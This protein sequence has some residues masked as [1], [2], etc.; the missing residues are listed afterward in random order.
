M[1]SYYNWNVKKGG[2]FLEKLIDAQ[3]KSGVSEIINRAKAEGRKAL[4]FEE[5][6]EIMKM[7]GI[8][9]TDFWEYKKDLDLEK[10]KYPAAVKID[11]DKILHKTDKKGLILDIKDKEELKFAVKEMQN[12]FNGEKIIIQP[13][14]KRQTELILGIKKDAIFGPI[15]MYGLGGI[16]TEMLKTVDFAVPP[17]N[18]EEI[19][20]SLMESKIKFLFSDTRG[21]KAYDVEELSK[22]ILGISQFA[23]ENEEFNEFDINPL[24]IYNNK[25]NA[26]AVDVKII[27]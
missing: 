8:K 9:T 27:I 1:D 21:Q 10:I 18:M 19:K 2:K 13:M 16:Y 14:F 4:Y 23:F 7:Y 17:L 15:V 3:R 25:S 26:V 22:I 24:L 12:N 11:S 20:K 6:S 5:A